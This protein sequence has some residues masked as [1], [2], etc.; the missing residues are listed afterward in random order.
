MHEALENLKRDMP[1]K[2][3]L[4]FRVSTKFYENL[5]SFLTKEQKAYKQKFGKPISKAK[6]LETV[7]TETLLKKRLQNT[8]K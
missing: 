5:D 3:R 1:G 8:K 4:S 7:V 6:I 2:S